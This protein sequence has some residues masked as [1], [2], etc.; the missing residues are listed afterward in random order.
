MIQAIQFTLVCLVGASYG[1]TSSPMEGAGEPAT[2]NSLRNVLLAA[3]PA[4]SSRLGLRSLGARYNGPTMKD[5]KTKEGEE[6][7]VDFTFDFTEDAATQEQTMSELYEKLT[8]EEKKKL[9]EIEI[10][11]EKE[12]FI[13]RD[14]G[15]AK[16]T[17]CGYIY[18]KNKETRGVQLGTEF[19]FVPDNFVCPSCK[20]PKA[21]FKPENIEIA[22]FEDNQEYGIG[23]N[24]LTE[25][26]KSVLIFG[27]LFAFFLLFL[28]GYALN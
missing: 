24:A 19:K 11:R 12:K 13:Q 28:A 20:A 4:Q 23:T 8:D 17:N 5:D 2:L 9:K 15:N 3:S 26:Q 22:G 18:Y 27:G 16:C 10:M 21:Y 7:T 14:T 6:E 25:G 1:R